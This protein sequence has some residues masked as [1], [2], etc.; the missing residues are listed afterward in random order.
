MHQSKRP[1]MIWKIQQ[2]LQ[3]GI[4]QAALRPVKEENSLQSKLCVCACGCVWVCWCVGVCG[5][6]WVCGRVWACGCVGVW[7]CGRVW[8]CGSV[9]VGLRVRGSGSAGCGWGWADRVG[10]GGVGG[11]TQQQKNRR[12]HRTDPEPQAL[13]FVPKGRLLIAILGHSHRIPVT[14]RS[15]TR[16]AQERGI[17]E[18]ELS[19][20]TSLYGICSVFGLGRF[21]HLFQLKMSRLPS[22]CQHKTN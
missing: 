14:H 16:V 6:V 21:A 2:I 19:G 5:C 20:A 18:Y 4:L 17:P 9:G 22:K 1:S 11:M 15:L 12:L 10:W 8:V 3:D 7:V 13:R